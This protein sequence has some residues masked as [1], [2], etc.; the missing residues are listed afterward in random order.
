[1]NEDRRLEVWTKQDLISKNKI[2]DGEGEDIA[3][4]DPVENKRNCEI[5]MFGGGKRKSR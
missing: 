2:E 4:G 1:M 3:K 5:P